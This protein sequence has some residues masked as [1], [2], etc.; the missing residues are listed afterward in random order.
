MQH[1]VKS[2]KKKNKQKQMH[3][4]KTVG[5]IPTV[6]CMSEREMLIIIMGDNYYEQ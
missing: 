6:F 3:K 1:F 2:T 4:N 5:K